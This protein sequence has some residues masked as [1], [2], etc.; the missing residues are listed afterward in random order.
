MQYYLNGYFD[1]NKVNTTKTK[2]LN[3]GFNAMHQTKIPV[4][5]SAQLC[6]EKLCMAGID[7]NELT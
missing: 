1:I 5:G 6:I 2:V 3:K 4:G 7:K